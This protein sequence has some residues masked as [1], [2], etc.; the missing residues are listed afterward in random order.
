MSGRLE[1][2]EMLRS[3]LVRVRGD[4]HHDHERW[5]ARKVSRARIDAMEGMKKGIDLLVRGDIVEGMLLLFMD[6]SW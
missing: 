4:T 1:K 3:D 5:L 6:R 2:N